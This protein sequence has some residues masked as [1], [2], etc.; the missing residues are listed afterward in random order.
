MCLVF[1]QVNRGNIM[2][3]KNKRSH[4]FVKCDASMRYLLISLKCRHVY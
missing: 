3:R 4:G 1:V 2:N